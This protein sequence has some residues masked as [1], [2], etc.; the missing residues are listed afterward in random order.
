MHSN[1]AECQFSS[2]MQVE[3]HCAPA[4][5]NQRRPTLNAAFFFSS[6][7][8]FLSPLSD[9]ERQIL[10]RRPLLEIPKCSLI[11]EILLLQVRVSAVLP[12]SG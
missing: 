5:G 2:F 11:T 7:H 6:H 4:G 3:G 12:Q 8:P 9:F 10:F 1:Q